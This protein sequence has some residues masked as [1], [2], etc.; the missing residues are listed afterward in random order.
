MFFDK[1]D[2]VSHGK[3]SDFISFPL[4]RFILVMNLRNFDFEGHLNT[5]IPFDKRKIWRQIWFCSFKQCLVWI[6][7]CCYSKILAIGRE[8]RIL[9][10]IT[11]V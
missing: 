1:K 6:K 5:L 8:M 10:F 9:D 7:L 11:I 4:F 3:M 2:M